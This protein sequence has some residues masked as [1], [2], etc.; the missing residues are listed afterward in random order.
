MPTKE[1]KTKETKLEE[2]KMQETKMQETLEMIGV[3]K[4]H[5]NK[6]NPRKNLGDLSELTE[7][8]KRNGVMQNLTVVRSDEKSDEYTVLIGHRRLA[9]AKAA[10][11]TEVP[12]KVVE[13]MDKKEQLAVMLCENLQRSD[14]T[15]REQAEGFQY[16]LD[17]GETISSISKKSGFSETTVRH[18]VELA[19]LDKK[20]LQKKTES[21]MFQLSLT[22]L[23]KLEQ[24][25]DIKERNAILQKSSNGRELENNVSYWVRQNK[26]AT[27]KPI[28]IKELTEM[29]VK[30]ETDEIRHH[31]Y[32]DKYETLAEISLEDSEKIP[33]SVKAKI[34]TFMKDNPKSTV[35][36]SNHYSYEISIVVKKKVVREKKEKTEYD[37]KKK[38]NRQ[39]KEVNKK[40]SE[41]RRTVVSDVYEGKRREIS[42]KEKQEVISFCW[43]VIREKY[44]ITITGFRAVAGKPYYEDDEGYQKYLSSAPMWLQMLAATEG[45]TAEDELFDYNNSYCANK[46]EKTKAFHNLLNKLYGFKIEDDELMQ[47]LNGTH[48]L[49]AQPEKKETKEAVA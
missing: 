25:A 48:E 6:D 27:N 42:E 19:K 4:L 33:K 21:E 40:L 32:T 29:G 45:Y 8:I 44:G 49:Y 2:T 11:L 16:M 31:Y 18:R 35:W 14:L 17:L 3:T 15:V 22:D 28:I 39:L 20:T 47:Y 43:P 36:Y 23:M 5:P 41:F 1:T 30:P 9:A 24:V 46:A 12:C 38:R 10:G 13:K 26:T 7:S 34:N 37:R